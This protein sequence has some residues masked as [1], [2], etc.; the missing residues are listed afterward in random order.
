MKAKIN[1]E[2]NLEIERAGKLVQQL[3]I[4]RIGSIEDKSNKL[5]R[6]IEHKY[7]YKPCSDKCPLFSEPEEEVKEVASTYYYSKPSFHKTGRTILTLCHRTHTFD[8]FTD[9]RGK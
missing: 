9:M 6:V 8:E 1:S 2:G 7:Y 3:C 5:T 4:H